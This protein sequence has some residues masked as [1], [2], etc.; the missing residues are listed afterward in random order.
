MSGHDQGETSAA[1]GL[2][3]RDVLKRGAVAGGALLWA[4]PVVQTLAAPAFASGPGSVRCEAFKIV[5]AGS[6]TGY[7]I[8][9]YVYLNDS[10][11][12]RQPNP[13]SPN[14]SLCLPGETTTVI[15]DSPIWGPPS[16]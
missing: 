12:A 16:Q 6:T 4:T 3:R 5:P 2:A 10:C 13:T 9:G 7:P 8:F 14:L 11:C 1:P 15:L